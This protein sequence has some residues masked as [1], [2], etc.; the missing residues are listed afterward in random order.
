M[1]DPLVLICDDET[2]LREMLS[3]YLGKRGFRVREA[4][5]AAELRPRSRPNRPMRSFSTSPC[6]ARMD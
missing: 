4:A 6:P 5:N 3:E 2:D 1:A